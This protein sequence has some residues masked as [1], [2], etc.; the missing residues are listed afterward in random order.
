ME[1]LT[2]H[3]ATDVSAHRLVSAHLGELVLVD[4]A[5]SELRVI[6]TLEKFSMKFV[7]S[8]DVQKTE[9]AKVKIW[10]SGTKH[11]LS[12]L[13]QITFLEGNPVRS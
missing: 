6:G 3:D 9:A 4:K 2:Y 13:D 11:K 8:A 1:S 5:D 10:V 7:S 12:G